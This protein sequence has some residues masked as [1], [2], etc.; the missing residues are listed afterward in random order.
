MFPD[1]MHSLPDKVRSWRASEGLT[2]SQAAERIG[3]SQPVFSRIENGARFPN[4][5]TAAGFITTGVFA[6]DEW[7][8]ALIHRATRDASAAA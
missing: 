6:R 3:L 8:A 2:Q 1:M 5:S 4:A 7:E